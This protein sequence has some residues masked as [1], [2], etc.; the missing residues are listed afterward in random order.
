MNIAVRACRASAENITRVLRPHS[1]AIDAEFLIVAETVLKT[2]KMH[3]SSSYLDQHA[4]SDLKGL[5][6]RFADL[7]ANYSSHLER[8]Q[9]DTQQLLRNLQSPRLQHPFLIRNTLIFQELA[10]IVDATNMILPIVNPTSRESPPKIALGSSHLPMPASTSSPDSSPDDPKAVAFWLENWVSDVRTIFSHLNARAFAG[11]QARD[12]QVLSGFVFLTPPCVLH[13]LCSL[14]G[15]HRSL[16]AIPIC[17]RYRFSYGLSSFLQ[18]P[19]VLAW[20]VTFGPK[21]LDTE[22]ALMVTELRLQFQI[23]IRYSAFTLPLF[24]NYLFPIVFFV[25]LSTL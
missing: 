18:Q 5:A 11:A 25:S 22:L 6:L 16:A 9:I 8:L 23:Y 10:T 3:L 4:G 2:L 13:F 19:S 1:L 21:K 12:S 24:S 14:P 20:Y 15:L 7:L 17:P